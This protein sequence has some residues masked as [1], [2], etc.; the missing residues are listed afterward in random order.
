MVT[1]YFPPEVTQ[2]ST[3]F[4]KLQG[5]LRDRWLSVDHFDESDRQILVVPSLSLDQHELKKIQ[6][7][8]YYEERLLVSIIRLRNPRTRM[9]YVTSQPLHPSIIDYYL[10]L[11]PGIPSAHARDRLTLFSTY[12]SSDKP[13]TQKI[14]ERPRLIQRMQQALKP[15]DAYMICYNSTTLERELS[16][17]LDIPLLA[18][19]PDLLYWD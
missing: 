8:H 7:V 15:Q 9:I 4:N 2:L 17:K 1:S 19:D 11:L 6:G 13:L 14:L 5:Q 18:L 16:V 3:L 12:D 10:E